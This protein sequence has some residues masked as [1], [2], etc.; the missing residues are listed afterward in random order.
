MIVT[1]EA[2]VSVVEVLRDLGT[3]LNFAMTAEQGVVGLVANY[4]K[5]GSD[6][7]HSVL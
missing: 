1:A 5:M 2:D 6:K 3:P 4:L 7:E